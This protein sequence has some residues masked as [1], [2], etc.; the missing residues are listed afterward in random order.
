MLGNKKT[1]DQMA[2]KFNNELNYNYSRLH[3][4]NNVI[5]SGSKKRTIQVLWVIHSF[6][7]GKHH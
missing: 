6:I 1:H 4:G 3:K 5:R 7:S 2:S